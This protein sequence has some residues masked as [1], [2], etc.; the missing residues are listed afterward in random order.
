MKTAEVKRESSEMAAEWGR[1]EKEQRVIVCVIALRAT[2][3]C[4]LSQVAVTRMLETYMD[5][6]VPE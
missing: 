5:R 1:G 4:V 6:S 3:N 2:V